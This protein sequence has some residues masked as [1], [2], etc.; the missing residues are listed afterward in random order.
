MRPASLALSLSLAAALLLSASASFPQEITD[1]EA[2]LGTIEKLK[3]QPIDKQIEDW[4]LFLSEHPDSAFRGEIESNLRVLEDLQ[5]K[6]D[7]KRRKEAYDTERYMRAVEYA[8]TLS[9]ADQAALWEQFLEENPQSLF[10][11]EAET[12]LEQLRGGNRG[13]P[14][15]APP[16]APVPRTE[17]APVAPDLNYKD[18]QTALLLAIFPGLVV[19]GMGHWYAK[20]YLVAGV[21]TGL[22]VVALGLGIPSIVEQQEIMLIVASILY[23]F[24]YFADVADA[25]F[26]VRRY[27]EAL[28]TDNENRA[29]GLRGL[30]VTFAF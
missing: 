5:L 21:L 9:P 27:N 24:T 20:D 4:R 26:A 13:S 11:K 16:S 1:A 10:R 18:P 12:R 7:P 23:G 14:V 29:A 30:T 19:P 6:T 17:A 8:K 28:E 22:R 25:P 3:D 15:V 2:Y